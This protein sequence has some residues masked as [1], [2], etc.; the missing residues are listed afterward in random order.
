[1]DLIHALAL[2]IAGILGAVA[3]ILGAVVSK[4]LAD[5]FKTWT[6]RIVEYLV[7]RAVRSLPEQEQARREE[8]W[9]AHID[10][11]P[12]EIVKIVTAL[13][14]Q[15][16]SWKVSFHCLSETM[17]LRNLESLKRKDA[18]AQVNL[19]G[20]LCAFNEIFIEMFMLNVDILGIDRNTLN[21]YLYEMV[22]NADM[23]EE[24]SNFAYKH[25]RVRTS[26]LAYCKGGNVIWR[27]SFPIFN[28]G[29]IVG[30][31]WRFRP[32]TCWNWP[33]YMLSLHFNHLTRVVLRPLVAKHLLVQCG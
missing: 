33:F 31:A 23:L 19:E 16:A 9:K 15:I 21:C 6:P 26:D 13:G 1:M 2:V 18:F 20:R 5:D 24:V 14:F 32:V 22:D 25:P 7:G 28:A 29:N 3:G 27:T 10:E 17:L 8:E 12:G 11:T 4:L 30:R